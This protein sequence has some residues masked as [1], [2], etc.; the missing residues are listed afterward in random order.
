MN[1]LIPRKKLERHLKEDRSFL[2]LRRETDR[3]IT[4]PQKS[5]FSYSEDDLSDP[6]EQRKIMETWWQLTTPSDCDRVIQLDITRIAKRV[7]KAMG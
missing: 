1:Y 6:R 7:L 2:I 4:Q 3:V 5:V